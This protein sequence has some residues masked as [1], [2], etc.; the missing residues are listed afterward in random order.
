MY[1]F[2]FENHWYKSLLDGSSK[3]LL[4]ARLELESLRLHFEYTTVSRKEKK[5]EAPTRLLA[6]GN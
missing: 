1:T 2:K 6:L 3:Y 5:D 4:L